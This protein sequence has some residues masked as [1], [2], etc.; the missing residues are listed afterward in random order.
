MKKPPSNYLP[1]EKVKEA[2]SKPHYIVVR[3]YPKGKAMQV[4]VKVLDYKYSWGHNRFLVTP[5]SGTGEVWK[6]AVDVIPLEQV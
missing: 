3:A 2:I 5:A 1:I 6:N 4:N